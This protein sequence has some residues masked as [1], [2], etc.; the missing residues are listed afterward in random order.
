MGK[1]HQSRNTAGQ[2]V[3]ADFYRRKHTEL[4]VA[5]R[6]PRNAF[7]VEHARMGCQAGQH[8]RRGIMF[9]PLEKIDQAAPVRLIPQVQTLRP[10]ARDNHTVKLA[11]LKLV[12]TGVEVAEVLPP[13]LASG[14]L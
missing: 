5:Q 2:G 8:R 9:R 13:S 11:G 12:E 7:A 1:P 6:A 10:R 3:L 4:L 14:E